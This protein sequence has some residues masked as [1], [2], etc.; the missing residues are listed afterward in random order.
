MSAFRKNKVKKHVP[1]G[2]HRF[3]GNS[4]IKVVAHPMVDIPAPI[5]D[6]VGPHMEIN[7]TRKGSNISLEELQK[8][9]ME[10]PWDSSETE[11]CDPFH[12]PPNC[13]VLQAGNCPDSD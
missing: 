4:T 7:R 13:P 8:Q 1:S 12:C 3:G 5:N 6:L 10:A 2:I 9:H 11:C